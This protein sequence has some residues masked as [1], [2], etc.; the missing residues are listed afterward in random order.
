[1][2]DHLPDLHEANLLTMTSGQAKAI[3]D[4]EKSLDIHDEMLLR[5]LGMSAKPTINND[6]HIYVV[7]SSKFQPRSLE[8]TGATVSRRHTGLKMIQLEDIGWRKQVA[9]EVARVKP[10]LLVFA[11]EDLADCTEL[12]PDASAWAKEL[13]VAGGAKEVCVCAR[14]CR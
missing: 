14:Q 7:G 1:M 8:E 6:L 13:L 4:S 2:G 9:K 3:E 10:D 5:A 11:Y 12:S